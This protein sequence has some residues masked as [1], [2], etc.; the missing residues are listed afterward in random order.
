MKK[1]DEVQK[2]RM[3]SEPVIYVVTTSMYY[4]VKTNIMPVFVK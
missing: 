4:V 3:K 2:N 1:Q